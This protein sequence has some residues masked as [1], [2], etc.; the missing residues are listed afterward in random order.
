MQTHNLYTDTVSFLTDLNDVA[1][2]T[3]FHNLAHDIIE[4]I[5]FCR[6]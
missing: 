3:A 2:M 5:K 6:Y 1:K 4:N